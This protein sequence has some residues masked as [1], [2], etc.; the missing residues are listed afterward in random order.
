MGKYIFE[1][2]VDET[3]C[4]SF[5]KFHIEKQKKNLKA[6][7]PALLPHRSTMIKV[8]IKEAKSEQNMGKCTY[9]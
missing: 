1:I 2:Q 3:F 6:H 5:Y 4:V 8:A 9:F 7:A